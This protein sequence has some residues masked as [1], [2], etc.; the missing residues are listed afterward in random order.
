MKKTLLIA[1][2]L[3]LVI[4]TFGQINC[5]SPKIDYYYHD[6]VNAL[7]LYEMVVKGNYSNQVDI[8][9]AIHNEVKEGLAA[10]FNSAG[11]ERDSIFDLYCIHDLDNIA[12]NKRIVVRFDETQ[13]WTASWKNEQTLTG[14]TAVDNI[15]LQY[16]LTAKRYYN[17]KYPP[18]HEIALESKEV[19]NLEALIK[20]FDNINGIFEVRRSG[21]IGDGPYD[22]SYKKQ[23]NI[24]IYEFTI[25]WGDCPA[26]C[27][28]H[29]TWQFEVDQNCN[30]TFVKV[31]ESGVDPQENKPK[32]KNCH[33]TTSKLYIPDSVK[34]NV[35]VFPNP[36][37]RII[38]VEYPYASVGHLAQ[39]ILTDVTGRII[40]QVNLQHPSRTIIDVSD[41][42]TGVYIYQFKNNDQLVSTGKLL[43]GD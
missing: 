5:T 43:I 10:I 33:I 25:Q 32:F 30:V 36:A 29:R 4:T 39:F 3:S 7:A 9:L 17:F 24:R 12:V 42:I 13:S 22:I 41:I 8:D 15:L 16:E 18:R 2:L 23:G 38:I 1:G 14:N 11:P 31:T 20:K 28:S 26:G 6:D 34:Q 21:L 27:T 35:K 40:K 19:L 37:S